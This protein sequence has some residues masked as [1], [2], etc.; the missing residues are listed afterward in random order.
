MGLLSDEYQVELKPLGKVG[1][2]LLCPLAHR[3]QVA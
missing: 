1:C 2:S 3:Y